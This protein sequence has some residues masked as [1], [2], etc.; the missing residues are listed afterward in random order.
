MAVDTKTAQY[1]RGERRSIHLP[2]RSLRRVVWVD[3]DNPRRKFRSLFN[4]QELPLSTSAQYGELHAIG[5][6][7]PVQQ[8]AHTDAMRYTINLPVSLHA[9]LDLG[10]EFTS[11]HE[12]QA[13][14]RSFLY[15]NKV[16]E[17]PPILKMVWPKTAI[18]LNTVRKVDVK[19]ERWDLDMNVVAYTISLDLVEIRRSFFQQAEVS[20]TTE[21]G[22]GGLILVDSAFQG[23]DVS[24]SKEQ[25]TG[26]PFNVSGATSSLKT[27]G[28]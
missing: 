5:W 13:F 14:F 24:L 20:I 21:V 18:V 6:S 23:P 28:G 1:A 9:Y 3:H 11:V 7:Q 15:A 8:Y 4:P 22:G 26:R 10:L 17:S 27:G 25:S 16:G 12:A 2:P 19:F